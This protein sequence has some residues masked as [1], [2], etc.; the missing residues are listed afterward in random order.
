M[1]SSDKNFLIEVATLVLRPELSQLLWVL[2]EPSEYLFTDG[3]LFVLSF[4]G[5]LDLVVDA[6]LYFS[7]CVLA[8]LIKLKF[9]AEKIKV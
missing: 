5:L 9:K 3:I 4:N 7:T 8:M 6:E 1:S 2:V